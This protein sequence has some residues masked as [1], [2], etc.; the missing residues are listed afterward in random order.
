MLTYLSEAFVLGLSMGPACLGYC[1]PVCVPFLA[2]EQRHWRAGAR[3]LGLFL[4][5]RLA[6]Y[7]VVGAIVG[8]AGTLLLRNVGPAFWGGLRILMGCMLILFGLFSDYAKLRRPARTAG[9][10]PSQWFGASLGLLTGINLCPPF[11]AAIAG[12][13]AGASV[14]RALF[15]FWAFFAGT[16]VY[17]VPLLALSPLSRSDALRQIARISLFLAGLWLATEGLLVVFGHS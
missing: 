12:A 4:L 6:G 11:G 5:G 16:A 17:F 13:A 2:C 7:S 8:M 10:F 9:N 14:T 15:Y 3:V 1:A